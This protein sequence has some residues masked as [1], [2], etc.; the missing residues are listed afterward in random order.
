M[1][2]DDSSP[3]SVDPASFPGV[4]DESSSLADVGAIASLNELRFAVTLVDLS[5]FDEPSSSSW[6]R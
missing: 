2:L 4:A 6:T 1:L 5:C 3:L